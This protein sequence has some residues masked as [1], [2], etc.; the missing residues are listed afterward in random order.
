MQDDL[1]EQIGVDGDKRRVIIIDYQHLAYRYRFSKASGLSVRRLVNG[2]LTD[3]D[4]TIPAYTIK[5]IVRWSNYGVNPTIVCLDS[6]TPSRNKYFRDLVQKETETEVT[7]YKGGRKRPDD[8]F[9]RGIEIAAN[10][11]QKGGIH[12]FKQDNY[13]ADDLIFACVMKAKKDYPYLPID[14]ITGDAD[15][16]PLVDEQVSVYMRS[17]VYTYAN[18]VS[19]TLT[20]YIQYT[21]ESY[22]EYAEQITKFKNL[23]VPYN[24]VLLAKILRGDDSDGLK[25]KPDWKPK[26]YKELM[27]IFIENE[28]PIAEA[29][30]Y[31]EWTSRVIDKRTGKE[32]TEWEKEDVPYLFQQY[33][34]PKELT[35][36]LELIGKYC[37][38]EDVDFVRNRYIGMCL[39]G[40][41]LDLPD[42]YKRRPYE[43]KLNEGFTGFDINTMR[44][45]VSVLDIRLPMV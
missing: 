21:P 20:N 1:L 27:Q 19:P 35:M 15:L 11:M 10:L 22:Q 32:V 12:V 5:Q 33:E 25:G 7:E 14:V 34:E 8:E 31:G 6:P 38:P 4:T 23:Y 13:E 29:C 17:K 39:N 45:S 43:I 40:A 24:T 36:L 16:L 37:E 44:E 30:R 42:N 3:I 28:E 26:M 18:S 2:I 9:Y 41:F